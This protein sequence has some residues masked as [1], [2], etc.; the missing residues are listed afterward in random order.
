MIIDTKKFKEV[1]STIL[2]AIDN[3]ELS[4]LT[5]ALELK[6]IDKTLYLNV[7]NKEYFIS[8]KF[9]LDHEEEFNATVNAITFLK[10]ISN[11]T[12]NSI[13]LQ[14]KDTY[15]LV[16]ANGNYKI[17]LIFDGDK[18]LQL[19]EIKINNKTLNM[20]I[21]GTILNSILIY[22]SKELMKKTVNGILN[23]V[24]YIDNQGCITFT[25]GACVNNFTLEKPVKLLLNDRIV[26]LFKLFKNDMVEFNLGYDPISNEI[27]QTK[28]EFITKTI[29]LKAIVGYNDEVINSVPANEIRKKVEFNYPYSIVINKDEL[30]EALNRLSILTP[31]NSIPYCVMECGNNE[32]TIYDINK[33]N[34]EII[35]FDEDLNLDTPYSLTLDSNDLKPILS[36]IPEEY[37]TFEFGDNNSVIIKRPSVF[38]LLP[39]CK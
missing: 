17:P 23:K 18:L 11:I 13:E 20:N 35:K 27:I 16:K 1:C 5:E 3:S 7:T 15:V 29:E 26:R 33:Q 28:I 4:N 10:L 38:N 21:S 31:K 22:N 37:I 2:V 24:Y 12:S 9:E 34:S 36:S 32:L 8:V 14:L 39:V 30:I 6:V 19:P 25:T